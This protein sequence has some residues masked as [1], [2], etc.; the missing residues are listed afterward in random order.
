MVG[1]CLSKEILVI[2]NFL[3][4]QANLLLKHLGF[5]YAALILVDLH[6]GSEKLIESYVKDFTMSYNIEHQLVLEFMKQWDVLG[7]ESFF[8]FLEIDDIANWKVDHLLKPLSGFDNAF[9]L[10][11]IWVH[12]FKYHV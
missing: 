12:V 5:L 1:L 2:R 9:L 4:F 6:F 11:D 8:H 3:L 7:V 10:L